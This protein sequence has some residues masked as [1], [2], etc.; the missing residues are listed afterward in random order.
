MTKTK[1]LTALIGSLIILFAAGSQLVA[2]AAPRL[3]LDP[4]TRTTNNGSDFQINLD[5]DA[6][7]KSVTGA[8]ASLT[9]PAADFDL[10]SVTD[11]GFFTDF[12]VP[13]KANGKI[14][15]R[16]YFAQTFTSKSGSGT[17]AVLT[18]TAKKDS[19]TGIVAF[20]CSG[21]GNDTFILDTEVNNI[22]S[23]GS[24]NQTNLTYSSSGQSTATPAPTNNNSSSSTATPNTCGGTCG[25]DVNCQSGYFCYTGYCRNPACPSSTSC[26]CTIATPTIKPRV[27]AAATITPTPQA[28]DLTQYNQPANFVVPTPTPAAKNNSNKSPL[29]AYLLY[30]GAF[31]ILCGILFTII[32]LLK[33]KSTPPPTQIPPIQYPPVQP[34]P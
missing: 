14:D 10:K 24:L 29:L 1:V 4:A 15:I 34:P 8:E 23:C 31:V 20:V 9:Y 30:G 17:F 2:Q 27:I 12:S 3:Y 16:G 25:S 5:I 33:K 26:V 32:K 7:T 28:G 21:S 6:E 18:F 13:T 19:G 11:G 22:L